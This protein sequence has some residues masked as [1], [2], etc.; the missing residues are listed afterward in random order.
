MGRKLLPGP[1][2]PGHAPTSLSVE[3]QAWGRVSRSSP[4][5]SRQSWKQRAGSIRPGLWAKSRVRTVPREGGASGL[6]VGG[7]P[8]HTALPIQALDP[9]SPY[10][11]YHSLPSRAWKTPWA[12]GWM[13]VPAYFCLHTCPLVCLCLLPAS[14][15]ICLTACVTGWAVS[16]S[17]RLSQV[18]V[19]RGRP[20]AHPR[21]PCGV[22]PHCAGLRLL[23]WLSPSFSR[24]GTVSDP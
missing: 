20:L 18:V 21:F 8:V 14:M 2:R 15:H 22:R 10:L 3:E 11:S 6:M 5:R 23:S 7:K 16:D 12:S 13:A 24:A 4:S 9:S 1:E 17:P 19:V